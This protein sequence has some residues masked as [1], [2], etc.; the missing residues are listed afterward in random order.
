MVAV[1]QSEVYAGQDEAV[2]V[3]STSWPS[4]RVCVQYVWDGSVGKAVLDD[5]IPAL[6]DVL[7]AMEEGPTD[8]DVASGI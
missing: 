4:H 5:V 7:M 8:I 6:V 3:T 1:V 2:F